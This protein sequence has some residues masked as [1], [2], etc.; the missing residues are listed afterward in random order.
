MA[1]R[2][3]TRLVCKPY[4]SNHARPVGSSALTGDS[5]G[6]TRGVGPAP[7]VGSGAS[8]AAVRLAV[9]GQVP[10]GEHAADSLAQPR[11]PAGPAVG[12]LTVL[13]A[14]RSRRRRPHRSCT[15]SSNACGPTR[16]RQDAR[17]ARPAQTTV[18][19]APPKALA[20]AHGETM[21][22]HA[23]V[24][25]GRLRPRLACPPLEVPI[26]GPLNLSHFVARK[27]WPKS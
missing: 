12:P 15:L 11:R 13:R 3:L 16:W 17:R 1:I 21:V 24:A 20:G 6:W 27:H 4:A 25:G 23:I 18:H 19:P 26:C 7:R 2:L 22:W 9:P 14:R 8:G 5:P 10:A